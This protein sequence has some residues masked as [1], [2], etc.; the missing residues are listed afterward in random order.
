MQNQSESSTPRREFL[1]QIA[2]SA[3]ALA[4]TA[5]AGSPAQTA[6]APVATPN[7][8]GRDT[9]APTH[10]DDSWSARLTAKHKALFDMPEIDD[11][12]AIDHAVLWLEGCRDA[13]GAAPGDAH[14]VIVVRHT[15]VVLAFNDAMWS[16]YELGKERKV[17]DDSTGKWAVR[18]PYASAT[19][20]PADDSPPRPIGPGWPAGNLG[21]FAQNGHTLLACDLAT[22]GMSFILAKKVKREQRAVYEELK[23]NLIP[24]VILQPSGIYAVHRAQEAG[25]T[26]SS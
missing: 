8:T 26:F 1:G 3:L 19:A 13:L 25:C 6:P 15:A 11:G 24:G 21:W 5:C 20:R 23:A 22:R 2:V 12:T 10:W 7:P 9:S 18:N 17:K 4:G 16:K 14:A